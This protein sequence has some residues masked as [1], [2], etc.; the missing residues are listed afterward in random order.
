MDI[1]DKES[2]GLSELKV[3]SPADLLKMAEDL[4]IAFPEP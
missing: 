4:E 2:I 3:K 1:M